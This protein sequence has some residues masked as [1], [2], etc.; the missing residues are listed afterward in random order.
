MRINFSY[1]A[2]NVKTRIRKD[3][4]NKFSLNASKE[5]NDLFERLLKIVAYLSKTDEHQYIW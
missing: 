2:K 5:L 4:I 3:E 1:Q